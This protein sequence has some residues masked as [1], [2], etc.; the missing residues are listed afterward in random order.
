MTNV[1]NIT[2]VLPPI[3]FRL[4]LNADETVDVTMPGAD[5]LDPRAQEKLAQAVSILAGAVLSPAQIHRV[6]VNAIDRLMAERIAQGEPVLD[7]DFRALVTA[8]SF[9]EMDRAAAE[10]PQ[11]KEPA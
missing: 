5:A 9:F 6:M 2:P 8:C 3:S 4:D 10:A 1:I 7:P 11:A